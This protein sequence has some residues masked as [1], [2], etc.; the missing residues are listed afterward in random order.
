MYTKEEIP[1]ETVLEI[2]ESARW[3][4]THKHTEPWRFKVFSGEAKQKLG[5]FLAEEYKRITPEDKFL[6]RKY[7]KALKNPVRSSH[8]IAI[9]MQRDPEESILEWEEIASVAMAVQNMWLTCHSHG[10]GCYWS[11]PKTI[12][13]DTAFLELEEGERCLGVLYMGVPKEGLELEGKRGEMG[14]KVV[15]V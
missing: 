3:A 14:E 8:V 4:P 9:C 7:K 2:M 15:W 5:N 11:S 13:N 10:I 12:V 6:E 1:K